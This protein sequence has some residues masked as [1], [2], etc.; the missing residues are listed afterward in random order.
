MTHG[1]TFPMIYTIEI[2]VCTYH[3]YTLVSIYHTKPDFPIITYA[4]FYHR[5]DFYIPTSTNNLEMYNAQKQ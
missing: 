1:H 3:E 4:K 2:H 5:Y